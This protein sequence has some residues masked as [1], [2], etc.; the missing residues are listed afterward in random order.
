M[1]YK[2]QSARAQYLQD[3]DNKTNKNYKSCLHRG[4]CT[5]CRKMTRNDK[6]EMSQDH[7]LRVP[8]I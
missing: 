1:T 2:L 5:T 4:P 7:F 3:S 8:I 6:L